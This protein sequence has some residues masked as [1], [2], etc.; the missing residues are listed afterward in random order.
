MGKILGRTGRWLAEQAATSYV[1]GAEVPD[2]MRLCRQYAQRG[3]TSAICPWDSPV[4]TP[5][6]VCATYLTALQAIRDEGLDCYLSIKAPSLQYSLPRIASLVAVAESR[7][8]RIHFDS[9][10]LESAHPS[11]L[12]LEEAVRLYGGIGYT[13]PSRWK[14]SLADAERVIELGVAV[15]VVKGQRSDPEGE[16]GNPNAD[17]LALVDRLAG[18]AKLVAIATHDREL[19]RE[20]LRRLQ[21]AGTTCELEQLYGL[22]MGWEQVARPLGVPARI[23]IPYG[24]AYL[25]YALSEVWRRPIIIAW[26]LKDLLGNAL[27]RLRTA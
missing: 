17:F 15:R 25:S 22:P 9:L 18:R 14:R 19:A 11:L 16:Q 3:I 4:D 12:L 8:I 1:A 6:Q 26:L 5:D 21:R 2:A 27:Q 7:G 23:Y 24:H 20:S 13:L 10:A